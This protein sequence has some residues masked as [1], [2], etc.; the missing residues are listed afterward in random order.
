MET[1]VL[2]SKS[3]SD[4]KLIAEIAR[5]FGI[6]IKILTE[7]EKEEMGLLHAMKQGRTG[8]YVDTDTFVKKLRK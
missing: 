6:V 4:L 8:K 5:K 3:K 2:Q 7:E 1:A